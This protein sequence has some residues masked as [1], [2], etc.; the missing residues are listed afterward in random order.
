MAGTVA[1]AVDAPDTSPTSTPSNAATSSRRRVTPARNVFMR[2]RPQAAQ[3]SGRSLWQR[4]QRRPDSY[5]ATA[6]PQ[7]VHCASSPQLAQA[8]SRA[9]PV[10]S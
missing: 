4:G 8:R 2:I 1:R 6:A 7:V 3:I 5:W 10:R 9:R